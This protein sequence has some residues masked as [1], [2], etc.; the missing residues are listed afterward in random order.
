[1]TTT[2]PAGRP[3]ARILVVD[4]EEQIRRI[5]TLLL[6]RVPSFQAKIQQ[7]G[8]AQEALALLDH[9][10]FDLIVSDHNMPGKT[11][12]DL[13]EHAHKQ[14][15][16]TARMLMTALAQ[17]DI[18]V[19]AINR[20]RVD[21]FLRKPFDNDAFIALADS[22][23]APRVKARAAMESAPAPPATAP[24]PAAPGLQR[25]GRPDPSRDAQKL[26]LQAEL[27]EV[28][29]AM[30]QLR[31]KLGLGS[32]SPEGYARV[33]DDLSKKRAEIEVKLLDLDM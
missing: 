6:K 17:L 32:M 29:K 2:P 16:Q 10:E 27:A 14:H 1:L 9:E 25:I 31:V 21:A 30:R 24:S 12:I 22:L 11:G 4:D 28:E 15:P 3:E 20:G 8:N 19:D 33:N 26:K 7:A 13:L 5:V 18:G 23:L